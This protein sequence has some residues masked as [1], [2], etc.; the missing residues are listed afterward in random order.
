MIGAAKIS[1]LLRPGSSG[2][3]RARRRVPPQPPLRATV[4]DKVAI[5]P[6]NTI[7]RSDD[8]AGDP[9]NVRLVTNGP[10]YIQI[11]HADMNAIAEF[12]QYK[13]KTITSGVYPGMDKLS[14]SAKLLDQKLVHR[15]G[16]VQSPQGRSPL[17][18]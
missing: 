6:P 17:L 4:A 12:Q 8:D 15:N 3:P 18:R 7:W 13:A 2:E 16:L 5:P 10:Y 1:A 14:A 9:Q 11:Y